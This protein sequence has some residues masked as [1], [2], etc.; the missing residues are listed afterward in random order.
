MVLS[1][2]EQKESI[3]E[4]RWAYT[5]SGW[6][7]VSACLEGWQLSKEV[8]ERGRW[9]SE[10][11]AFRKR[12]QQGK[13]LACAGTAGSVWLEQSEWGE[14]AGKVTMSFA[15]CH[16]DWLLLHERWV[17]RECFEQKSEIIFTAVQFT[18]YK[19]PPIVS[20]QCNDPSKCTKLFNHH[21]TPILHF[22]HPQKIPHACGLHFKGI[23]QL[24]C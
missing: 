12:E 14:G 3:R 13:G 23:T 4:R 2:V 17:P 6:E 18:Y 16:N 22:R 11:T 5:W 1:A 19:P 15:G 20:V 7:V 10:G 9:M 21:D 8:K 24:L